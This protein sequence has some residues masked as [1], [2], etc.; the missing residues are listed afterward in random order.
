MNQWSKSTTSLVFF[1]CGCIFC[2]KETHVL[3]GNFCLSHIGK[4]SSLFPP[5]KE[6]T[7]GVRVPLV[8]L[9]LWFI[10]Y[11][12]ERGRISFQCGTSKNCQGVH[13]FPWSKK[14]THNKRIKQKLPRSAWV[15]LAI[16]TCPTLERYLSSFFLIRDE[17]LE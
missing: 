3:L 14:C 6:W 1:Y 8:W 9:I 12:V 2:F 7:N 11:K 15:S 17:P 5:Y 16:F 10:P 4:I 13:E